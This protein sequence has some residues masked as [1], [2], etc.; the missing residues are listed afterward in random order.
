ME[1]HQLVITNIGF[2]IVICGV[3]LYILQALLQ[4]AKR[5]L[6]RTARPETLGAQIVS[7]FSMM[8]EPT[9][10]RTAQLRT[11]ETDVETAVSVKELSAEGAFIIHSAPLPPGETISLRLPFTGH[12][13]FCPEGTVVWNNAG[14][15]EEDIVSRGMRIRFRWPGPG[16]AARLTRILSELEAEKDDRL[17]GDRS[18]ASE[19][20]RPPAASDRWGGLP[21]LLPEGDDSGPEFRAPM[22]ETDEQESRLSLP[23]P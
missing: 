12:P 14:V 6:F 4:G 16:E 15:A 17:P 3:V 10:V 21:V 1:Q 18:T 23:L 11:A 22:P 5:A 20:R 19:D 7:L 2:A 9:P 8:P 13:D